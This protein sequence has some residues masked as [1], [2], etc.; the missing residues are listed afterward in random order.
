MGKNP[1]TIKDKIAARLDALEKHLRAG[2]HLKSAEGVVEVLNLISSIAKFSSVLSSAERDFVNAAKM[3][4]AA[5]KPW[6]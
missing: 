3:A 4:V 6:M 2:H 5:K 1:V